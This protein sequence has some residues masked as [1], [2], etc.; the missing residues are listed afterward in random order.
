MSFCKNCGTEVDGK[1]CSNCGTKIEEIDGV[2]TRPSDYT[3]SS[4]RKWLNEEF[5]DICFTEEE[6]TWIKE[7]VN[8]IDSIDILTGKTLE[9]ETINKVFLLS[10]KEVTNCSTYWNL[11]Y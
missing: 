2:E 5:Y 7:S 11:Y 1:F 4:I 8:E 10:Y 9:G 3:T 6:K